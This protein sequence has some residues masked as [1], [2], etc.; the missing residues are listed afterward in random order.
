MTQDQLQAYLR[1]INGDGSSYF[2]G[3]STP[4]ATIVEFGDFACPFSKE[5]AAA[6][7]KIGAEYK[8]KLKIVWRDYLR[9]E[10]SIDLAVSARCA[11]EQGKFWEMHD[12]LFANQDNFASSTEERK[13]ELIALAQNLQLNSDSF[14]TCL[15]DR[16]YLDQIKADYEDG[17]KLEIIGTPTWFVNNRSFSGAVSEEKLRE[18]IA[19]LI[20]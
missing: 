4:Q 5:S 8:D 19:G 7:S 14:I 15:K 1:E 20:K 16:K 13:G 9:N 10:D 6:V 17:N 18:L 2:L 12:G 11:G 3:T